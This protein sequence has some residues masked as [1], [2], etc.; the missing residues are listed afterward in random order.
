M[1][2]PIL[3]VIGTVHHIGNRT[4]D[5]DTTTIAVIEVATPTGLVELKGAI[6][7]SALMRALVVGKQVSISYTQPLGKGAKLVVWGVLDVETN[8]VFRDDRFLDMRKVAS[9]QA[10]GG[11]MMF[12]LAGLIGLAFFVVPGLV[13]WWA[14]F[15][16]WQ[17]ALAWPTPDAITASLDALGDK[18][19]PAP[20]FATALAA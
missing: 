18:A 5:N 11:I 14:Y 8:R 19:A 10:V 3:T 13:I 6:C 15:K 1:T 16:M 7:P 9:L 17:A 4:F 20:V 12:G 2:Y